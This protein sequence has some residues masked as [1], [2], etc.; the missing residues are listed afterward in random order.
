M[1]RIRF[2]VLTVFCIVSVVLYPKNLLA[3]NLDETIEYI[4]DLLKIHTYNLYIPE[5][6]DGG[7]P[8]DVISVDSHGKLNVQRYVEFQKKGILE[9]G[10][11][12]YAYLKSLGMGAKKD[13]DHNPPQYDLYLVCLI[14][15]P[16][17]T[18]QGDSKDMGSITRNDF[19]FSVDNSDVRE[20][21]KNALSHLLELAK[22]N[23]A[24][25]DK[26]PFSN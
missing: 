1:K 7:R 24:F 6:D 10:G 21:L 16:C 4:N 8:Y 15:Y 12:V 17:V 18:V 23:A 3:Q 22:N 13:Y 26:D 14:G 2:V 5:L 25:Y 19:L 20:R 9:K 11:L